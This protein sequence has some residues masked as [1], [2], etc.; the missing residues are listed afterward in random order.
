[1]LVLKR[2]TQKLHPVHLQGQQIFW[3]IIVS[4]CKLL[5]IPCLLLHER[6]WKI[7]VLFQCYS[8]ANAKSFDGVRKAQNPIL[9]HCST[10]KKN[11]VFFCFFFFHYYYYYCITFLRHYN[12]AGPRTRR[13][14]QTPECTRTPTTNTRVQRIRRQINNKKLDNHIQNSTYKKV[15]SI[16]S[17]FSSQ[18]QRRSTWS[19]LS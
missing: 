1:M 9:R 15:S 6:S 18:K 4:H 19:H 17:R 3:G 10:T 8:Y 14:A 11:G 12:G 16:Y 13:Q 7:L 5:A 2:M